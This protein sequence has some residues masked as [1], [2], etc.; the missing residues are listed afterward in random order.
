M[1]I[2]AQFYC[3]LYR[4]NLRYK[5]QFK[6]ASHVFLNQI[7]KARARQFNAVTAHSI[8]AAINLEELVFRPIKD[9]LSSHH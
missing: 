9:S 1:D 7:L 4:Q 3:L 5:I 2:C 6:T 8:L